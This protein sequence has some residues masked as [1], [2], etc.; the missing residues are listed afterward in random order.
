MSGAA[1]RS[2]ALLLVTAMAAVAVHA[3]AMATEVDCICAGPAQ[4]DERT[5]VEEGALA[6]VRPA[7]L[8]EEYLQ[9]S[10]K[11][12][13]GSLIGFSG[14]WRGQWEGTLDAYLVVLNGDSKRATAFY[15]WGTNLLVR[16]GGSMI[17][18]GVNLT[19]SLVFPMEDGIT[20]TF[21][22][23]KHETLFGVL[24]SPNAP[25]PSRIFMHRYK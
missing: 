12:L 22:R 3:P 17:I 23:D 25:N 13:P 14:I 5:I 7:L 20:F 21:A 6:A 11:Q 18:E 8:P 4:I 2:L 9:A 1:C 19:N 15:S 10:T 24:Y 16:K